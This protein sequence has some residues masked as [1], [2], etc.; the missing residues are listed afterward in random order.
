MDDHAQN[1]NTSSSALRGHEAIFRY[2]VNSVSKLFLNSCTCAH[3][4]RSRKTLCGPSRAKEKCARS[5]HL[6]VRTAYASPT[7]FGAA[8]SDIPPRHRD[9]TTAAAPRRHH[10]HRVEVGRFLEVGWCVSAL[11][12]ENTLHCTI[13]YKAR[14]A[15][16]RKQH[17]GYYLRSSSGLGLISIVSRESPMCALL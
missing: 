13:Q 8:I 9:E 16:Q 12:W 10:Q 11:G 6:K 14:C 3:S 15:D 7:A 2:T 4:V 17:G 5:R 1:G